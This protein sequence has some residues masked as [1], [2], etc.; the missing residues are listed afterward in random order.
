MLEGGPFWGHPY[1][2]IHIEFAVAVISFLHY[3]TTHKH[4]IA[5]RVRDLLDVV[6]T[7]HHNGAWL[8]GGLLEVA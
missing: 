8:L 6:V 1:W 7:L 3:P 4:P 5:F 2:G